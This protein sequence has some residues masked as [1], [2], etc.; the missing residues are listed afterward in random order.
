VVF[1]WL[2]LKFNEMIWPRLPPN[3][4]HCFLGP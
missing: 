2:F 1:H 4:V 3:Y